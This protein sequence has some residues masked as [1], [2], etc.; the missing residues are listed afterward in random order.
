MLLKAAGACAPSGL[1]RS[2]GAVRVVSLHAACAALTQQ[3]IL[4]EVEGRKLQSRGGEDLQEGRRA[5]R[6]ASCHDCRGSHCRRVQCGSAALHESKLDQC[7]SSVRP[8]QEAGPWDA[9]VSVRSASSLSSS[10]SLQ[11][12]L[13][14]TIAQTLQPPN[15]F[16]SLLHATGSHKRPVPPSNICCCDMLHNQLLPRT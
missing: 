1:C 5:A 16:P 2:G 11:G 4:E 14:T 3:G 12:P 6:P 13:A 9:S 7:S 8:H 15:A 10:S